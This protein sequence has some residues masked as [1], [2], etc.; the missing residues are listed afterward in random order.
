MKQGERGKE[1][2]LFKNLKPMYFHRFKQNYAPQE[3]FICPAWYRLMTLP[4]VSGH[5]LVTAM[6]ALIVPIYG[7]TL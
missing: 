4:V 2:T 6:F 5:L 3:N 1:T 7:G